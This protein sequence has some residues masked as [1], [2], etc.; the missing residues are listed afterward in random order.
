MDAR[1]RTRTR[2]QVVTSAVL[3]RMLLQVTVFRP[4]MHMTL[5]DD[6]PV[7]EHEALEAE[8]SDDA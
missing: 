6:L 8:R 1:V 5:V 3:T 7:L 2:I 4:H